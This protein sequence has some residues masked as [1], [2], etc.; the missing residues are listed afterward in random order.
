VT[1][2]CGRQ[3]ALPLSF[4]FSLT[5]PFAVDVVEPFPVSLNDSLACRNNSLPY[6]QRSISPPFISIFLFLVTPN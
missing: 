6:P 1:T 3:V 4:S 5:Q 2:R